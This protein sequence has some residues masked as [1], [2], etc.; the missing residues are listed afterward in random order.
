MENI[1]YLKDIDNEKINFLKDIKN[2][3]D[4]NNLLT[5]NELFKEFLKGK[6]IVLYNLK[7]VDK[8]SSAIIL[9]LLLT[10]YIIPI[11]SVYNSQFLRPRNVPEAYVLSGIQ[12]LNSLPHAL[13]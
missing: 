11:S 8:F 3:L 12:Y 7:Y 10:M 2:D 5:Y 6:D 9:F 4:T 1:Y 13:Q